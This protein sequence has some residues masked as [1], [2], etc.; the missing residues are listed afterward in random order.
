MAAVVGVLIVLLKNVP[1]I[2]RLIVRHR[3]VSGAQANM[4]AHL[5]VLL[6]AQ[7]MIKL[8][9]ALKINIGV[10]VLLIPVAGGVRTIHQH[11]TNAPRVALLQE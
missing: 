11:M 3:V 7:L 2:Q 9:V 1:H 8:L 5:G 6:V 10:Q 4:A